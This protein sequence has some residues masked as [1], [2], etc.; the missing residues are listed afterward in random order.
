[1]YES[2]KRVVTIK[3]HSHIGMTKINVPKQNQA[4]FQEEIQSFFKILTKPHYLDNNVR[5]NK[6]KR[7]H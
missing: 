1:M 3:F 6:I 4:T 7:C 2:R 5:S